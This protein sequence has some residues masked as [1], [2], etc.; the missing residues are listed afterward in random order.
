MAVL[1]V[2]LLVAAAM[3][4]FSAPSADSINE[5]QSMAGSPNEAA[6]PSQSVRSVKARK[7]LKFNFYLFRHK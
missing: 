1:A 5:T 7:G 3:A 2:C 4:G 6:A